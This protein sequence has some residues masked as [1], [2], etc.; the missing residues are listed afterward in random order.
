MGDLAVATVFARRHLSLARVVAQS[1]RRLHPEIPFFALLAD[2]PDGYAFADEPFQLLH[3]DDLEF[4]DL[5]RVRFLYSQQELTYALT[6]YLLGHLLRRGFS[7]V[8]FFK[9][10]SLVLDDLTPILAWL[11]SKSIVLTPHLLEPLTGADRNARELNVLQSGVY[12][13]GFIGVG[14]TPMA[15]AFLG[16]W[17]E[18]LR[19]H[20]RHAVPEGMHYEQRWLDLVP[21]FFEDFHILRD[22]GFNVGHWNLPDREVRI[23]GDAVT[24]NG[25][26][27]RF[28]RFSGF[29]PEQPHAATR[30]FSRLNMDNLGDAAV[31]FRRY[32]DLLIAAGYE[33]T[34]SLPYAYDCFDNGVPVPAKVREIYRDL[35]PQAERFGDPLK[36]SGPDSFFAWL[37]EPDSEWSSILGDPDAAGRMTRLWRMIYDQRPD[38]RAEFPDPAGANRAEFLGWIAYD[39]VQEYGLS[40]FAKLPPGHQTPNAH[41]QDQPQ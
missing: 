27:C 12:N 7:G 23:Q 14:N 10:E 21:A 4:T 2:E 11:N 37:N 17:Q 9:Q 1:F 6:P 34:K 39:G 35:G 36:T 15:H 28:V 38:V 31:L 22:P 25:V 3:V 32:L 16:W 13:V 40:H 26:P 19:D 29:D 18:R 24:V 41:S 30:Y 8:G 5:P 33:D 20:C